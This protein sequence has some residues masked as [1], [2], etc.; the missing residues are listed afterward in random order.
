MYVVLPFK[1]TIQNCQSTILNDPDKNC[2]KPSLDPDAHAQ[3]AWRVDNPIVQ[4]LD[5]IEYF[6]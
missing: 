4:A 3:F 6:A 2:M 1:T 5:P